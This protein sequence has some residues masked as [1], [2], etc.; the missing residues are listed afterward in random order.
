MLNRKTTNNKEKMKVLTVG[1]NFDRKR[2]ETK[3]V[4]FEQNKSNLKDYYRIIDCD[5]IDIVNYSPKI[6][7]IVDDEGLLKSDNPVFE[8]LVGNGKSMQ[9]AGKLVFTKNHC[10][11]DGI[12]Q[13]GLSL[14]DLVKLMVNLKIRLIGVTA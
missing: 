3:I 4:E 11:D 7:I 5:C 1:F 6:A 8:L 13:V 12:Y 9:L 10:S 2:I 14:G